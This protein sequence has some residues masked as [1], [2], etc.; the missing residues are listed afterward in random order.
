[1]NYQ[2]QFHTN[3]LT[4]E[5]KKN[6]RH[7]KPM[8]KC[9]KPKTDRLLFLK[10]H[11]NRR[12]KREGKPTDQQ[13]QEYN[14]SPKQYHKRA[15]SQEL[16]IERLSIILGKINGFI[17]NSSGYLGSHQRPKQMSIYSGKNKQT[18]GQYQMAQLDKNPHFSLKNQI[19]YRQDY[20]DE[21]EKIWK[22]KS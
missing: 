10:T 17:C 12:H 4:D 16:E 18:V 7:K 22:P 8:E 15:L 2:K 6:R 11:G 21:F 20:L 5:L 19:Y 14:W 1:M 13:R 9:I 3:K